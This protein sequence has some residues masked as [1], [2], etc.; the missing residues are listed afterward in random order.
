MLLKMDVIDETAEL[1]Q[2]Q[3][4]EI[5]ALLNYAAEKETIETG[6]E[7]AVIFV[8]NERIKE[9]NATYRNKDCVTDVISFAME[10]TTEDEIEIAGLDM[11]RML[12]DII[13]SVSK[14][15]EQAAEYN[16]S[17]QRELGFLAVHGFLHLLGFDHETEAEEKEMFSKQ[18]EILDAYG[19]QR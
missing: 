4:D 10:E 12:G 18:K 1:T 8:S 15:R 17:F 2:E 14:A 9:I 11:P 7:L 6:T 19:L 13:I 5:T 3:L 16:H